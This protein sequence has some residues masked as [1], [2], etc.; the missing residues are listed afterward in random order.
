LITARAR[1]Y[2]AAVLA[3]GAGATVA[4]ADDSPAATPTQQELL[5][6]I[7]DLKATVERLEAASAPASQAPASQPADQQASRGSDDQTSRGAGEH[8]SRRVVGQGIN[9]LPTFV[10]PYG[11]QGAGRDR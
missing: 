6:Q 3:I 5:Q 11:T 1:I 10:G 9:S 2:A 8:A 7:N 4:A